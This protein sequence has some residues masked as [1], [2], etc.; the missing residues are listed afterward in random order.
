MQVDVY[1][2]FLG[3]VEWQEQRVVIKNN[4]CFMARIYSYSFDTK[5]SD[6]KIVKVQLINNQN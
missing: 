1:H 4:I 6:T 2:S 3:V 5:I